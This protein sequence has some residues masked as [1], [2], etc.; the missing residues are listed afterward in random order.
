MGYIIYVV[1]FVLEN[2]DQFDNVQ[3]ERSTTIE[4]CSMHFYIVLLFVT[5]V[6]WTKYASPHPFLV[7]FQ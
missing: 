6:I 3:F 1:C 5:Q 7:Y 2:F 4:Y